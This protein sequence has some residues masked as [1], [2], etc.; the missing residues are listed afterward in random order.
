MN[1]FI[2][3]FKRENGA[4]AAE[5]GL[6]V[7]LIAIVVIVGVTSLGTKLNTKFTTLASKL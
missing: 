1:T 5:Y 7:A 2:K 3:F 4:S 6:L